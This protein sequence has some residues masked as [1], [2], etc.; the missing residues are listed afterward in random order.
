MVLLVIVLSDS[1][2]LEEVLEAFLE[3][4][5][6][7]ATVLGAQG[8]GEILS[9]EVPIFAG[10]RQLFPGGEGKHRLIL[11]VTDRAKAAEAV[12]LLESIGG[13]LADKGSG[14]AFTLPV[15]SLWG[16]AEEL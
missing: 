5:V 12:G 4:G 14:I 9:Q 1:A 2:L 11:S 15:D 10:L 6:Q 13:P 16:L 7:G 8:M 3:I